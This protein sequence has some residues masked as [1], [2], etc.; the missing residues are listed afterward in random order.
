MDVIK[1][2]GISK[3]FGAVQALRDVNFSLRRGE[4]MAI[5]GDNGAGKSTLIK[6]IAGAQAADT[7]DYWFEG[8]KV[9]V[10]SPEAARDLG[11]ETV[12][13]D[14]A[15]FDSSNVAEN[16]FA[17]REIVRRILGIPFLK[18]SEMHAKSAELL[19]SLRIHIHSTKLTVK[20]MSGGQRQSVAVARAAAFGR[21]VVIMDEPTAALGVAEQQKVLALIADLKTRGFSVIVISHNLGHVFQVSDRISV[22]RQGTCVAVR[23]VKE[24]TSDEIVK[25]ITGA[26]QAIRH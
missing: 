2:E 16:I 5:V 10:R 8:Q 14:L 9:D 1:L 19:K 22:M 4:V 7:G 6:T 21:K 24:T 18:N 17:G 15:L 25:L 23:V 13:Q 26:D 20:A 11:I 3:R 12:Y